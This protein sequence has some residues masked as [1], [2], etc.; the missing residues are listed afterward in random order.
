MIKVL[1]T[2]TNKKFFFFNK[3]SIFINL[4]DSCIKAFL[5]FNNGLFVK[6]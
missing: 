2:K 4:N 6:I 5:N 3:Y 1:D